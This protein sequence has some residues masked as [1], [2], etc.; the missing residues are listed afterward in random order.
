MDAVIFG[1]ANSFIEDALNL[2]V[3]KDVSFD[4]LAFFL[5]RSDSAQHLVKEGILTYSRARPILGSNAAW[6]ASSLY[7]LW[8]SEID[9]LLSDYI[10]SLYKHKTKLDNWL[11]NFSSFPWVKW[12]A[13]AGWIM[14]IEVNECL[15]RIRWLPRMKS[16]LMVWF[17][18][19]PDRALPEFGVRLQYHEPAQIYFGELWIQGLRKVPPLPVN[20]SEDDLGKLVEVAQV[21]IH[22]YELAKLQYFRLVK[23]SL[24]RPTL[25]I[26]YLGPMEMKH[27]CSIV[28]PI[29]SEIV[30]RTI[31]CRNYH[32]SIPRIEKHKKVIFLHAFCRLLMQRALSELLERDILI[33]PSSAVSSA[34]GTWLAVGKLAHHTFS[35]RDACG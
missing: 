5:S 6:I 25:G 24:G 3:K 2:V 14:D 23:V 19:R 16:H 15:R 17:I 30:L 26:P 20:L 7:S 29:A 11:T 32:P 12:I 28:K 35:G 31:L 9:D 27:Y 34:W 22:L 18:E 13:Y 33:L 4:Q 1:R 21:P 10:D 8:Q